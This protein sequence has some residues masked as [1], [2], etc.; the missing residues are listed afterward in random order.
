MKLLIKVVVVVFKPFFFKPWATSHT[1]LA[2]HQYPSP[3]GTVAHHKDRYFGHHH[4]DL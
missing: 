4:M 2:L 3:A 1:G